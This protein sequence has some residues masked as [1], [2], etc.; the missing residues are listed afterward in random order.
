M[1]YRNSISAA[2]DHH[3]EHLS[4]T[5]VHDGVTRLLANIPCNP[6]IGACLAQRHCRQDWRQNY[7]AQEL[8]W[9][10]LLMY[11]GLPPACSLIM[12]MSN[13]KACVIL[14]DQ[15]LIR[16]KLLTAAI[17]FQNEPMHCWYLIHSPEWTGNYLTSIELKKHVQAWHDHI[18]QLHEG[19]NACQDMICICTCRNCISYAVW[20]E[21]LPVSSLIAGAWL[22]QAS[23]W[24][25]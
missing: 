7:N 8:H 6:S 9:T 1:R 24:G 15:D 25:G 22:E 4:L 19:L 11:S 21:T 3:D 16:L 5:A 12:P 10:Q 14:L 13:A 17:Q 2:H 20:D 18:A 23:G